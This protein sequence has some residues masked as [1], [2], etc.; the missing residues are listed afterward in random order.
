MAIPEGWGPPAG[1]ANR[2]LA[3]VPPPP[4]PLFRAFRSY[5]P[6]PLGYR[7]APSRFADPAIGTP[8]A[9]PFGT[10]YLG[11]SI[12]VCV[13]E[14]IIRESGIGLAGGGGI[15]V[16]ERE[17]ASWS[18]ARVT[19]LPHEGSGP[20]PPGLLDLQAGGTVVSRI[21]TDVIGASDHALSR[22]WAKAIHDHPSAPAG[23]LYPS[24][25]NGQTNLALFDRALG[26][27]RVEQVD[28]LLGLGDDLAAVLARYEVAVV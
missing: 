26:A 7:P 14:T 10:I 6:D 24:R 23:L 2:D 11:E 4:G 3:L 25:L 28:P 5:H 19:F 1:F 21:P 16:A 8:G 20:G 9:R 12:E 22:A 17:L 27:L 18:V 13:L 15:P